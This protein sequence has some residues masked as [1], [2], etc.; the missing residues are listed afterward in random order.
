MMLIKHSVNSDWLF[1][2]HSRVLQ[3]NWFILEGNFEHYMPNYMVS[4][5][6]TGIYPSPSFNIIAVLTADITETGAIIKRNR[7]G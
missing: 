2:T 3:V 4:F 5:V 7:C 1:K 6:C